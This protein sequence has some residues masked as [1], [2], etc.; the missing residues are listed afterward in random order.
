MTDEPRASARAGRGRD[1]AANGR[2]ERR[3]DVPP[4]STRGVA[5]ATPAPD[6]PALTPEPVQEIPEATPDLKGRERAARRTAAPAPAADGDDTAAT[7]PLATPTPPPVET[8]TA[9]ATPAA[10]DAE[11]DSADTTAE[12]RGKKGDRRQTDKKAKRSLDPTDPDIAEQP[13]PEGA[14]E[15]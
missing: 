5:A 14:D 1:R 4:I 13:E 10:P 8:P 11:A 6:V 3:G 15:P 9:A 12:A 2:P 7:T